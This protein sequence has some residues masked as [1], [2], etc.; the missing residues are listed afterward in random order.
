[1]VPP[2]FLERSTIYARKI[3]DAPLLVR[4][5]SG[6]DSI[7]NIKVCQSY[8]VDFIIKRN[9]RKESKEDWLA[10]AEKYGICCKER[11]G[12]KVYMGEIYIDK[13]L[14]APIRVVFKVIK[15]TIDST[16]QILLVP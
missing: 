3:T 5:D 16:G 11:P 6:H 1:M 4:M 2:Q 15:R 13:G 12:K 8:H 10:L 14:G 7:D 9:L